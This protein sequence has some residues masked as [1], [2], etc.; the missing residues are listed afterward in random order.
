[1]QLN[2]DRIKF[3]DASTASIYVG[4]TRALFLV[5]QDLLSSVSPYFEAALTTGFKEATARTVS[6]PEDDIESFERFVQWLYSGVYALSVFKTREMADKRYLQLAEL[7]I[8]ADKFQV[9]KLKND[10]IDKV[11]TTHKA[12]LP[13]LSAISH[14]YKNTPT[15]SPLRK[16]LVATYVWSIDLTWYNEEEAEKE[17][18]MVPE[19]TRDLTVTLAGLFQDPDRPNPLEGETNPYHETI[20]G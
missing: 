17:L 1:M 15:S 3:C 16:M 4:E 20:E 11:N 9:P 8:L 18:L 5:H 6:L 12:Y 14:V 19:F 13:P 10:I 2:F 7:Y